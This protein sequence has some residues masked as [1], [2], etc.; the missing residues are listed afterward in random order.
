M[1][2]ADAIIYKDAQAIRP[3]VMIPVQR[4]LQFVLNHEYTINCIRA[5]ICLWEKL[6]MPHANNKDA[7]LQSLISVFVIHCLDSIY[8]TFQ[9]SSL[10]SIYSWAGQ[11]ELYL[12]AN[13]WIIHVISFNRASGRFSYHFRKVYKKCIEN[14]GKFW[15]QILEISKIL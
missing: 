9:A 1:L 7:D 6:F 8:P 3:V 2:K 12:V 10:V 5:I 11:F 4:T 14:T 13:S 15:I